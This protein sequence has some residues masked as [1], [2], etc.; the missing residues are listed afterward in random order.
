MRVSADLGR[1]RVSKNRKYSKSKN[2]LYLSGPPSQSAEIRPLF[3]F[4]FCP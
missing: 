1:P 4:F 3:L 2:R